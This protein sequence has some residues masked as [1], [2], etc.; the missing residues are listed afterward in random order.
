MDQDPKAYLTQVMGEIDHEVARRRSS[1]ELPTLLESE[2]DQLFLQFAPM[3]ATGSLWLAESAALVSKHALVNKQVP[4]ASRKP[5]GALIKRVL[6]AAMGWYV[7]FLMAQVEDFAVAVSRS[8]HLMVN[9]LED[10]HTTMSGL[11]PAT[12]PVLT[13]SP[14]GPEWWHPMVVEQLAA[15]SGRVLHGDCG[16]SG[17]VG[18]LTQAGVDAYGID[19]DEEVTRMASTVGLDVRAGTILAHLQ[20]VGDGALGGLVM[21]GTVQWL[22]PRD[23][24]R[25][26][27]LA[28]TRV[29]IGGVVAIF[30]ATPES[31]SRAA[32]PVLFDLAPGRP[33][34]PETWVYLLTHKG[35]D[36]AEMHLGPGQSGEYVVVAHRDR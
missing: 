17:L 32:D 35:F 8:M 1:G 15:V 5:G 12:L 26:V 6:Q 28:A 9:D 11:E 18:S 14:G 20:V 34:H 25:L 16:H 23:A 24:E 4:V 31:W 7:R 22:V 3:G 2:L 19:P 29:A 36:R 10:I 13:S 33:L 21:E 27:A 30:S